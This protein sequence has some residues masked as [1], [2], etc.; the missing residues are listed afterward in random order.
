M[1]LLLIIFENTLVSKSPNKTFSNDKI[2][3]IS[4]NNNNNLISNN[5]EGNI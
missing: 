1:F 4:E 2:N 3:D 5:D